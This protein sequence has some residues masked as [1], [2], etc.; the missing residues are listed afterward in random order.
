MIP[1][2]SV[3]RWVIIPLMVKLSQLSGI[4][5][6]HV[7]VQ[8]TDVEPTAIGGASYADVYRGRSQGRIVAVKRL[9]LV[10]FL[11]HDKGQYGGLVQVRS[12]FE[13][14]LMC[15]CKSL[16]TG[17]TS[18]VRLLFGVTYPMRILSNSLG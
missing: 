5:P 1:E 14:L 3:D 13:T 11:G 4:I 18:H 17:R 7:Y 6:Q 16:L 12:S 15:M 10:M 8:V 9:R 2:G